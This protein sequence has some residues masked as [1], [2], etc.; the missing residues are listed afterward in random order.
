MAEGYRPLAGLYF[1]ASLIW[2][3]V[4][5]L[6][7][8]FLRFYHYQGEI[9]G[10]VYKFWLHTHS[11]VVM[12][13]WVYN[14]L[15]ALI[16]WSFPMELH[17]RW[18]RYLFIATQFFVAGILL[19]FPFRG[20]FWASILFST[21]HIFASYLFAFR[22]WH[23]TRA[24]KSSIPLLPLR[25]LH[26]ALFFLV[27][28]TLGPFLVAYVMASG[29]ESSI[30]YR[31]FIY[32]YLHFQSNG[33]FVTALLALLLFYLNR[34][35]RFVPIKKGRRAL[36]L[37]IGGVLLSYAQSAI[38]TDPPS[39]VLFTARAGAL[40]Q[41]SGLGLLL[42][43]I[44]KDLSAAYKSSFIHRVI[45]LVLLLLFFKSFLQLAMLFGGRLEAL[46][47][48]HQVIIA[49]LHLI[50]L[51]VITPFLLV[52]AAALRMTMPCSKSKKVLFLLF[53]IG[54]A[55]M[56]LALVL[57]V[58]FPPLVRFISLPAALFYSTLFM[59]IPLLGLL[60]LIYREL[61]ITSGGISRKD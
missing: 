7:A 22:V 61:P 58:L 5:I 19:S 33:W 30:W 10:F 53:L 48:K 15:V 27:F 25:F 31:L 18:H 43:A 54:F 40:L 57:P 36:T 46:S 23:D 41:I 47:E 45:G 56:E 8:L 21:L 59:A 3:A 24:L 60:L 11:H 16:L 55:L 51:G 37:F 39:W 4:A 17:L 52:Q 6:I 20:Y 32:F 42:F 9:E 35:G 50:F 1:L 34:E 38:W 2:F 44:R 28:S 29:Q 13:G 49:F 26:W 12:L 14:A